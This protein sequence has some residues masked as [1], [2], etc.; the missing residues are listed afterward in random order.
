MSCVDLT[1]GKPCRI[2]SIHRIIQDPTC[3]AE[4][5]HAGLQSLFEHV[6]TL[7]GKM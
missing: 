6:Y 7:G 3:N 4:N 2:F 5:S 1:V